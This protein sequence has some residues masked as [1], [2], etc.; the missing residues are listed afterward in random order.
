MVQVSPK[1]FPIQKHKNAHFFPVAV[2][3]K[4]F[5]REVLQISAAPLSNG[6]TLH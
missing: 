1:Q 5:S 6:S 2:F 4:G 3:P